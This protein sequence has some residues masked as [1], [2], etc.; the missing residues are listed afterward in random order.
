MA[1]SADA[2]LPIGRW[3]G[4]TLAAPTAGFAVLIGTVLLGVTMP[5]I[6]GETANARGLLVV[7]AIVLPL[8]VTVLAFIG[9]ARP[10]SRRGAW[11]VLGWVAAA[12]FAPAAV[13]LVVTVVLDVAAGGGRVMFWFW[14]PALAG[15][16]VLVL[17][18][19]LLILGDR[20]A[21]PV[22]ERPRLTSVP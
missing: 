4:A 8:F 2:R 13:L 9:F 19:R 1:A 18:V 7:A 5:S 20:G 22:I 16:L 14:L 17:W 3:I 10:A 12:V 11:R 6:E 21:Q 15:A